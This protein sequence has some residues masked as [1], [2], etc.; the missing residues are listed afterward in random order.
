MVAVTQNRVTRIGQ[1]QR[2]IFGFDIVVLRRL[3]EIIPDQ[4]AV[5]IGQIVENLFGVLPYPIADDIQIG[6][7]M[8]SE[9]RLQALTR[10]ALQQVVHAPIA[11][12]ADDAHSVDLDHEVRGGTG[13][14]QA[15]EPPVNFPHR[16]RATRP[17]NANWRAMLLENRAATDQRR[18][19]R[20]SLRA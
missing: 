11:A 2:R 14:A 16:V 19:F 10:D 17:R 13:I 15:R 12:A 8:Q 9:I 20:A 7:V 5:F 6:I 3:P 1:E 4:Q 18:E